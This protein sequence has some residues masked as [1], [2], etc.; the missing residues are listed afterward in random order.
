MEL[1]L[2]EGWQ[3]SAL[4]GMAWTLMSVLFTVVLTTS[5]VEVLLYVHKNHEAYWGREFRTS[6]STFTQ[7]LSSVNNFLSF[8]S[9][10]EGWGV[11]QLLSVWD[12]SRLAFCR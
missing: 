5:L 6:T 3:A 8:F 2:R 1:C 12:G 10:I 7:L 11:C 9:F 4:V